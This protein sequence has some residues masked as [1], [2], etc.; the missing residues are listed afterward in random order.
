MTAKR[1]AV[2]RLGGI[3]FDIINTPFGEDK[4]D[5]PE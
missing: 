1:L 3:R 4:C 2:A 5:D